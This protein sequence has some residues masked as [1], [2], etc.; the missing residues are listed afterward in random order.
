MKILLIY[1][2]VPE[3]TKLY[4]FENVN[5]GSELYTH[6]QACNGHFQNLVDDEAPEEALD[7]LNNYL[8]ETE[9]LPMEKLPTAG[10]FDAVFISGFVL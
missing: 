9:K 3:E 8:E 1:E 4:V 7:F 2:V 6:L 10:P 5:P